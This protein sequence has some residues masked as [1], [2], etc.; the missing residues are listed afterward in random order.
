M[1]NFCPIC[2]GYYPGDCECKNRYPGNCTCDGCD[3]LGKSREAR[4]IGNQNPILIF[5]IEEMKLEK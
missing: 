1:A 5:P 3:T 4:N 2:G